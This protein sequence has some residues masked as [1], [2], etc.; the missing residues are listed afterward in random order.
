MNMGL[1]DA[2]FSGTFLLQKKCKN[3]KVPAGI[4]SGKMY[5]SETTG[6]ERLLLGAALRVCAAQKAFLD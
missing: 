6:Q 4:A 5:A 3:Y 1:P 2:G